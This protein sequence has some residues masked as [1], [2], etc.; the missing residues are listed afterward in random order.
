MILDDILA[1]HAR[2]TWRRARRAAPAGG[3]ARRSRG[4]RAAAARL[5]AR[6]SPRAAAPA[7]IAEVKRASPSRGV[8]RAAFDPAAHRARL[9]RGRRRGDLGADRASASSSG[10]AR[11]PRRGPRR[12][13][14]CRCLRKDFLVDPYQVDEAR[15][16]GA[17][18]VLLIAAVARRGAAASCWR[19]RASSGST[20]WSRC[21]TARELDARGG[22]RRDAHRRQQPRPAH[23]RHHA[24]DHGAAGAA[25]SRRARCWSPRAASRRR[26]TCGAWW[27]PARAPSWS[28]RRSWRRPIRAPALRG[29]ASRC[30]VKVKI[31]GVT[32]GR[33][34]ARRGRGRRRL[35]RAQLHPAQPAL[36]STSR[37]RRR[38]PR[39]CPASP[40]VGVFV[41]AARDE[42]EAVADARRALAALQ[43]HGD[44]PPALL[45]RL[46]SR[47]P[48]RRSARRPGERP[49]RARR[50]IRRRLPAARHASSPGAP[51]GTGVALDPVARARPAARSGS[52]SPAA[53]ARH[54]GR[55]RA[56]RCGRSPSTW[57]PASSG[58]R[59]SR[60]MTRSRRFI[61]RA[62]AA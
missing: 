28:A 58:R 6:R 55:R 23:L 40:L 3:A 17:D 51:A 38:S 31:C 13:R 53:C 30:R 34:R 2:S 27:P 11:A 14:R 25:R 61:R 42:V 56:A 21:T 41:D 46:R 49:G 9:R 26:P 52:S 45:P 39:R 57:P 8:I 12:G 50:G 7:V 4:W 59:A 1:A 44:E 19:R 29:A 60:T 54:R 18:A 47:R 35:H 10:S 48:S 22:A 24:R 5:R 37:R 16:W 33:R 62:K 20:R 15:A 32:H 36:P 43:F